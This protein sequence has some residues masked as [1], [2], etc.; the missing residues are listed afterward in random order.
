VIDLVIP[1]GGNALVS[2]IQAN[3]KIPVLGHADGI[4]HIY[5]DA[6]AACDCPL[7]PAANVL[8]IGLA[9]L[10]RHSS[11][12]DSSIMLCEPLCGALLMQTNAVSCCLC[13]LLQLL[14]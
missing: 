5:V 12:Q 2:H 13:C 10:I 11:L 6:G 14:T 7:L 1:R 9:L 4:C 3:T 8:R